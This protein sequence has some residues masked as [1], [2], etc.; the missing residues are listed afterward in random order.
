MGPLATPHTLALASAAFSAVATMLIQRG[1]RRS[2]F[3]A[4]FWINVIVGAVGLWCAVLLLVPR[5]QYDWG[6][7]PYFVVSGVVGTAGGRLFRVVG[8]NKVGAPVAAAVNNL[9]PLISSLLAILLLGEHVTFP[10]ITGTLVIVLGTVLL[11]LSGRHVGFSP[12]HLGYPLIS[13]MCF[14]VVAII[15]KMGLSHAG[16]LFDSA[17][18]TTA[19]MVTATAFVLATGNH[20][21]LV[22]DA[23]SFL[24]FVGGG[25]CENTGV[26]LVLVALGLG[27]VSVVSPLA[28]TAPLFVLLLALLFPSS[29]TRLTWRVV[30]GVVLIVAGVVLLTGFKPALPGH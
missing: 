7:L 22:C 5:Q 10:I 21:A 12:R 23:R 4:G 14:G 29:A 1:L 25:I 3:Y 18:N 13:A 16:P 28:G 20:R 27:E 8:I 9:S 30:A 11:S 15:R 19:A 6:A 17:I 26:F 2:N 24:Y